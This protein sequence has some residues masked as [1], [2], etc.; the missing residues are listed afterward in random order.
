[1]PER[2]RI[3]LSRLNMAAVSSTLCRHT[4]EAAC[5]WALGC[6]GVASPHCGSGDHAKLDRRVEPHVNDLPIAGEDG[7][8]LF[9]REPVTRGWTALR[10]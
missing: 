6:E 9:R 3:F 5:L 7:W 2:V 1:M 4:D 10:R 8:R